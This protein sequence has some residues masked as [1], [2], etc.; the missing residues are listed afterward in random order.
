MIAMQIWTKPPYEVLI[1]AAMSQSTHLCRAITLRQRTRNLR[2]SSGPEWC[3][4]MVKWKSTLEQRCTDGR[5]SDAKGSSVLESA[6]PN[7]LSAAR[8][9]CGVLCAPSLSGSPLATSQHRSEPARADMM[10]CDSCASARRIVAKGIFQTPTRLRLLPTQ[11]RLASGAALSQCSCISVAATLSK[12]KCPWQ[13]SSEPEPADV[14]A[15]EVPLQ[16]CGSEPAV[17]A[18]I[19]VHELDGVGRTCLKSVA[20][21]WVFK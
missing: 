20:F 17:Y 21:V 18:K 9:W 2:T 1:A 16:Q 8:S 3:P 6:R 19:A 4:P 12:S 10:L 15:E 7:L 13:C 5:I 11:P 14:N